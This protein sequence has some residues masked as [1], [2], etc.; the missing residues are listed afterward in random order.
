[1][2]KLLIAT[3]LLLS[4]TVGYSAD[5]Y[6]YRTCN[7]VKIKWNTNN[8]T[9]R[10]SSVS[11]PTGY[12]RDGLQK[13]IDY[14]NRNPSP[15]FFSLVTDTGGVGVGNGQSE[16][17]GTTSASV[18]QGSPAIA[19][20]QITCYWLFG[21]VTRIDEED[22]AFDYN[23]PFQWT[24]D[25]VK[26]RLIQ[27]GGSLRQ[28]QGTAVHELGHALGLLHVNTEYNVMG[29]DF[30]HI[31][32]NGSAARGYLGEDAS[33]GTVFLYG[34]WSASYQDLGTVHW[35]Y[36]SASGEYSA[37]TK[38]VVYDA[39]GSVLSSTANAGFQVYNVRRGQTVQAEFTYENNGKSTQTINAGYYVSTNDI[40]STGDRRIG[41]RT[42]MT[43]ARDNVL[44]IRT[45]LRIPSDL[46][47]NT[48][49]WLG[50]IVDP[51]K[52]V[53]DN[54]PSNNATYLPILVQ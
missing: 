12:W 28:L 17:W 8:P 53:S 20:P 4:S 18:L 50:T 6:S 1:M 46:K 37:H 51:E 11:F 5:A 52:R 32:S 42:G 13:S 7:G 36:A 23:A 27:Y 26:S 54:V 44:T 40:I 19:I 38:T 14:T 31:W 3:A 15:F 9:M 48:R 39:N 43:L 35:K 2:R 34:L 45:T 49:Y 10:A 33:D 25:E 29:T 41:T 47:A 16:I 22:V 21:T 24:A 30:Q